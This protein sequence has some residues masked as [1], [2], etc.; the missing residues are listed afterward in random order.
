MAHCRINSVA[1]RDQLRLLF[2]QQHPT[3]KAAVGGPGDPLSHM[4]LSL[5]SPRHRCPA[6]AVP[7]MKNMHPA[8]HTWLEGC[9]VTCQMLMGLWAGLASC[10][11]CG[12]HSHNHSLTHSHSHCH[13]INHSHSLVDSITP[14]SSAE[15]SQTTCSDSWP[16][17]NNTR[18]LIQIKNNASMPRAI[19]LNTT[20]T[21]TTCCPGMAGWPGTH[22]P[23]R[24]AHRTP[25]QL[26]GLSGL[27]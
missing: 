6:Q 13:S 10:K 16:R 8:P 14:R 17:S 19:R 11:T 25:A 4:L 20:H 27:C 12:S 9:S 24:S 2:T 7:R 18:S 21:H 5:P 1:D 3:L 23:W 26:P 15:S 22:T